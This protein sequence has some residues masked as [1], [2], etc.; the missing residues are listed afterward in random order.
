MTRLFTAGA[1]YRLAWTVVL[2]VA[3]ATSWDGIMQTALLV[4]APRAL[5]LAASATF[6]GAA[7]LA[8]TIAHRYAATPYSG[9]LPRLFLFCLLGASCTLQLWRVHQQGY[10]VAGI[11]LWASPAVCAVCLH[12]IDRAWYAR[13]ARAGAGWTPLPRLGVLVWLRYPGRAFSV[14]SAVLEHRIDT[15]T[16][17]ALPERQTA[18]P[19]E[20]PEVSA[21][22]LQLERD[23]RIIAAL[24]GAGSTAQRARIASRIWP[25]LVNGETS[26]SASAGR[27]AEKLAGL[28][29][30]DSPEA[31]RNGLRRATGDTGPAGLTG[32]TELDRPDDSDLPAA[33]PVGTAR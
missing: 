10:G 24:D 17:L 9:L 5:A 18:A 22:S 33:L 13:Q 27:I 21:T 14:W 26:L 32:L 3:L 6:D 2:V 30:D 8:A 7:I 12:E 28:G 11:L 19:V 1:A 20:S 23:G 29:F 31:L 4:G 16:R 25:E 15:V